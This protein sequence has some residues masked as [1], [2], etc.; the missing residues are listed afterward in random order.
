VLSKELLYA[1]ALEED[2]L[3]RV[4]AEGGPAKA[5]D[6]VREAVTERVQKLVP[7]D[8]SVEALEEEGVRGEW[9][10]SPLEPEDRVAIFIHGG[11]WTLGSPA[12]SRELAAR[13]SRAAQASVLSLEFG[14]APEHPF[15]AARDEVLAAFR[16]VIANGSDPR[17]IAL[18]GE[19]TGATIALSA[20]LALR[21]AGGPAPG[22]VVLMSPVLD[23]S[24]GADPGPEDPMHAWKTVQSGSTQYLNGLSAEDPGASPALA[25]PTGLASLLIQVGTADPFLEQVRRFELRAREA[26]VDVTYREW[27]GM[28]HRWQGY[29]HI[30]DAA[31]ASDQVGDFLLQR[32]GPGYVPVERAA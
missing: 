12:E 3:A 8:I 7:D 31:R 21:D 9:V 30:H 10:V 1:V 16:W 14:L 11:G 18:V 19:S 29:P 6:S 5:R 28:V 22:T 15:P 32:L 17:E 4:D 25:D 13:I 24:A 20:A 27:E 23:L 2:L 26:G